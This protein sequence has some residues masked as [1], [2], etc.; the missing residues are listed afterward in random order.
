MNKDLQN[1]IE[2]LEV[3]TK[4]SVLPWLSFHTKIVTPD[5]S[6]VA[7]CISDSPCLYDDEIALND[8]KLIVEAVNHYFEFRVIICRLCGMI[9][10]SPCM[11]SVEQ[12]KFLDKVEA[13]VYSESQNGI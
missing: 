10:N 4:H 12:S 3:M 11:M 13:L 9:R 6:S 2:Q 7:E 5:G 8:A 1:H